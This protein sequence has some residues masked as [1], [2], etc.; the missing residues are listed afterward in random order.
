MYKRQPSGKLEFW[1]EA[2]AENFPDDFERQPMAKW[3]VGG[4]KSE[5]WHHDESL[6]GERCKDYPLLLVANPAR[7]RVHVPVSYTHLD[8]YK[9]QGRTW[10]PSP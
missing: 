4:P 8:V 3:I 5:G 2:L 9:R 6:W 10:P 7:F 1:S